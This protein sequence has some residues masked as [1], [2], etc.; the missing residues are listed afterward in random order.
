MI[1]THCHV[2]QFESPEAVAMATELQ[3]IFTIAV[4]NL[5]SHYQAARKHL[6]GFRYV[7]PSLG[8]HPLAAREHSSEIDL[9]RKLIGGAR[10]VGEVG[11]DFSTYGRS[12]A[13]QQFATFEEVIRHAVTPF[14]IV[15][16]HSRG[17]EKEVLQCLQRH[18]AGPVIF[19]WYSGSHQVLED[20]FSAGHYISI[21]PAMIITQKWQKWITA[22]PRDRVLTETDGPFVKT[23]G[24]PAQPADAR[25]VIDW[26]ANPWRCAPAEA[27]YI[28]KQNFDCLLAMI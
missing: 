4:T 22:L 6:A 20:I 15:T 13:D 17:A 3:A 21:N 18:D 26:L 11:L 9:F 28:V 23:E 19:H 27:E 25:R 14:R 8:M 12:T 16:I 7:T 24:K 1:D 10:F 5:P 2:D